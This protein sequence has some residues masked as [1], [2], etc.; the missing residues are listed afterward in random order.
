[1]NQSLPR[2]NQ[3]ENEKP[4]TKKQQKP[5]P[6]RSCTAKTPNYKETKSGA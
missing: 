3:T 1:V 4:K 5:Y 6:K 2:H